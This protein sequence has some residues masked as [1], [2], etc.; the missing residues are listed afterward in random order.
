M[1]SIFLIAQLNGLYEL[2]EYRMHET[3]QSI[4]SKWVKYISILL[5]LELLKHCNI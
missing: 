3:W 4:S 1:P 5:V 2:Q